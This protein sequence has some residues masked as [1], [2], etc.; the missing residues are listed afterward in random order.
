M[1]LIKQLEA[2]Q[3]TDSLRFQSDLPPNRVKSGADRIIYL[4][5]EEENG[6][7][8]QQVD[9]MEEHADLRFSV[10]SSRCFERG[11]GAEE[12]DIQHEEDVY[13]LVLGSLGRVR[14][15]DIDEDGGENYLV[16]TLEHHSSLLPLNGVECCLGLQED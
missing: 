8:G 4:D 16:S 11:V 5:Q 3:R 6:A 14:L 1:L 7:N 10:R 9:V 15:G 2:L 13:A 12:C